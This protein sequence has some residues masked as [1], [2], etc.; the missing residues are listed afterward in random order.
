[1]PTKITFAR[2]AYKLR[3]LVEGKEN[4]RKTQVKENTSEIFFFIQKISARLKFFQKQF[5]PQDQ[6]YKVKIMVVWYVLSQE[7]H[8]VLYESPTSYGSQVVANCKVKLFVK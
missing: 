6:G 1:M 8:N 7:I 3:L 5:K 2:G 4:T